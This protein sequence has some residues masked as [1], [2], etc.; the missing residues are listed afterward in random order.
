MIKITEG[1]IQEGPHIKK[2]YQA[3]TCSGS[4]PKDKV[5]FYIDNEVGDIYDLIADMSKMIWLLNKKIDGQLTP[6]DELKIEKLK[7]RQDR[8]QDIVE[9]YYKG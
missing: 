8:V 9:N 3:V 4:T 6:D 2:G 5:R 1:T 7:E